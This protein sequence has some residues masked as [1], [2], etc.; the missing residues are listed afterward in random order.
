MLS[1]PEKQSEQRTHSTQVPVSPVEPEI[2]RM[3]FCQS[4]ELSL[5][6]PMGPFPDTSPC[7]ALIFSENR[8]AATTPSK[9]L[10]RKPIISRPNNP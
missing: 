6:V 7:S 9:I 2:W 3:K 8:T 1:Q 4:F 5:E 10:V